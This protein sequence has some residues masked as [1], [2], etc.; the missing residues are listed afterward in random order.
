MTLVPFVDYDT[1]VGG[2]RV[3]RQAGRYARIREMR[4]PSLMILISDPEM[5]FLDETAWMRRKEEG[6]QWTRNRRNG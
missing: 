4:Q 1:S 3:Y 2:L 6:I 5:M